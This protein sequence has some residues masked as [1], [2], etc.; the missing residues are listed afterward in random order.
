[1]AWTPAVLGMAAIWWFSSHPVPERVS[2]ALSLGDKVAH[3]VGY[4]GLA[5]LTSVGAVRSQPPPRRASRRTWLV[6]ALVA[7]AYGV[8]DEAHQA[9][10]PSRSSD[11]LDALADAAGALAG[12]ALA[13]AAP[14]RGWLLEGRSPR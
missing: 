2:P 3:A 4:A 12:A 9:F 5:V 10:V 6:A 11:V 13:H 1:M 14:L 8:I 7:A